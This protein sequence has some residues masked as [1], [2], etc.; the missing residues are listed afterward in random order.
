M[1]A[2]APERA[3]LAVRQR[4][5]VL[6]QPFQ[7]LPGQ[8]QAVELRIA[9]LQH[10]HHAQGLGV[11]V[12]AAERG[13][14]GVERTLAGMAER[15]MAEIVGERQR[16]GQ[17]LVEAERAGER[18]RDLGHLERMGEPRAVMVALVEHEDL[19]LVLEAAERGRVNDAVAVAAKRD[20]GFCWPARRAAVRGC[21]RDRR[22][23]GRGGLRCRSPSLCLVGPSLDPGQ[24][25]RPI[26]PDLGRT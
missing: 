9:P 6:D 14:A 7:R 19:G 16:L 4:A 23:R 20:C 8:V 13:E 12:E 10:G 26:D 3:T 11:V 15:R 17:V 5:V 1:A 22:H 25:T 2:I 21:A 24:L 18:A